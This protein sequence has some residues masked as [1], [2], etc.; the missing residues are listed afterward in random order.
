MTLLAVLA[1]WLIKWCIAAIR[2]VATAVQKMKWRV[3]ITDQPTVEA[4]GTA[5]YE[6]DGRQFAEME[7]VHSTSFK[8]Q[9]KSLTTGIQKR[10]LVSGL[11]TTRGKIATWYTRKSRDPLCH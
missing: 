9:I 8:I 1:F 10:I 7:V 11:S 2:E 5:F 4:G 6:K 3:E